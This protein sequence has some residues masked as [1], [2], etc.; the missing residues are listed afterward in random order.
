MD[1]LSSDDVFF[2]DV[3]VE[4]PEAEDIDAS[5]DADHD[6]KAPLNAARDAK[7]NRLNLAAVTVPDDFRVWATALLKVAYA[8]STFRLWTC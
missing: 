3:D 4:S 8:C 1:I 2:S 7:N 5:G 6:M